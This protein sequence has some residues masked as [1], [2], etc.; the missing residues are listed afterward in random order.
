MKSSK[1]DQSRRTTTVNRAPANPADSSWRNRILLGDNL[2][3]MRSLLADPAVAGKVTLAYI[4]PPFATGNEF[5]AG[6]RRTAT[7]SKS[8]SDALAY[9]DRFSHSD[10]L[11]F[12]R[13]RLLLLRQLLSPQGSLWVHIGPQMSHHVRVLLDE[14]FGPENFLNEIARVKCNPK[15]FSRRAFGNVKDTL[16]FYSASGRHVWNEPRAALAESDLAK[17]FPRVDASGRRYTTTPLHAPGETRRGRTGI[18]W[19]GLRPP[20]GRHWRYDPDELSRLDAA[21]LIEWSRTG[22]PRKMIYADEILGRGM[23]WQDIWTFKDP[24][25]PSYPTEKNLQMLEMI[26]LTSSNPGDIVLDCFAGSGTT[27]V[28]AALHGR[29]W[30]GAD[31]SRVAVRAATGRLRALN[32]PQEFDVLALPRR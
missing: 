14:V 19:K 17:R 8:A 18:A 30:I 4:D 24:A 15:N 22:N 26:V 12:L 6:R 1:L 31:A 7:I 23:K 16:L 27:L 3:A 5:R 25:Y 11:K 32:P 10:Y 13:E 28:A 2:V 21:G 20:A 29:R 9:S